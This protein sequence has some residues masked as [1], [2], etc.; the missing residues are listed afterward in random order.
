MIANLDR[1]SSFVRDAGSIFAIRQLFSALPK[2]KPLI[3]N[4]ALKAMLKS[5]DLAFQYLTKSLYFDK[6][7]GANW[8][9]AW[10]QDLSINV[11]RRVEVEGYEQWTNKKG[12]IGVVPPIEVLK[13]TLTIRIHLDE[14]N[15]SNGALSVLKGSHLEGVIRKEKEA[16]KL[17]NEVLC[18]VPK[19]GVMLMRPLTMHASRRA[20][21]NEG[22]KASR[23][24]VLHLEL[25]DQKLPVPLEWGEHVL[26]GANS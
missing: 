20:Q 18:R 22:A 16:L 1:S 15:E 13:K 2:L 17:E 21:L 4:D 9:V 25:C 14:T 5:N 26:I 7:E 8:F 23:R 10:H 24:R 12:I 3:W 19:G 11:K 6:N